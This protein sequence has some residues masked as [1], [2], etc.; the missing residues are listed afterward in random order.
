MSRPIVKFFDAATEIE[1]VREM[2]DEEYEVYLK[3]LERVEK[4]KAAFELAENK[5][6]S[7]LQKLNSLGLDIEDLKALGLG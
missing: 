2:N 4:E 5:K 7:A 3:D 1:T 6:I